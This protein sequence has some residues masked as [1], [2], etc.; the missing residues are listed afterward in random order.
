MHVEFGSADLALLEDWLQGCLLNSLNQT[1]GSQTTQLQELVMGTA[2][3]GI[4]DLFAQG[5]VEVSHDT[6][7]PNPW[8]ISW[9]GSDSRGTVRLSAD[10]NFAVADKSSYSPTR[11]SYGQVLRDRVLAAQGNAYMPAGT[12]KDVPADFRA[13][14]I[15]DMAY[16]GGIDLTMQQLGLEVEP[17]PINA[18]LTRLGI[19]RTAPH[20]SIGFAEV[21]SLIFD[22]SVLVSDN[23][24]RQPRREWTSAELGAEPDLA[25][26]EGLALA[27]F[28]YKNGGY[29]HREQFMAV[30]KQFADLI[31][32]HAS[33]D[34]SA[35][36]QAN[37]A[38]HE[39]GVILT[40][41]LGTASVDISLHLSGAGVSEAAL[42]SVLLA[43]NDEVL[44]LDEPATNLSA[45]AQRRVVTALRARTTR[46]LQTLLITHSSP[47]VPIELSDVVRLVPDVLGTIV[48]RLG[49]QPIV[50]KHADLLRHTPVRDALFA[51]GVLLT[52]GETELGA[53]Q[54]WL[55]QTE[56]T[57]EEAGVLLLDVG[58][59][60]SL[61]PHM[62]VL[63]AIGVP[64]AVLADGPAFELR[65]HHY[66]K[67]KEEFQDFQAAAAHWRQYGVFT[68]ASTFGTGVNKGKGEF[69]VFLESINREAWSEA[70]QAGAGSKPRTGASF[71]RQV[72]IPG[73][74]LDI[75]NSVRMRFEAGSR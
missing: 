32:T 12:E 64:W 67:P 45:T 10:T 11:P 43:R 4:G 62:K 59:D 41:T 22:R 75:W 2:D 42:L 37:D 24:R 71:A 30:Q 51:S 19:D 50:Q 38:S 9:I 54:I 40:P 65:L 20:R 44:V 17:K 1:L 33:L 7:R 58:G 53:L 28:Q 35:H 5:S 52:E 39:P 46:G 18:T 74:I 63:D 47:L 61:V 69:E 36:P 55:S 70:K 26:G 66:Q 6:R 23:E 49:D 48:T 3:V 16:A 13:P 73:D 34:V 27:L 60:A 72:S 57:L 68:V 14:S 21:A 31:S 8:K 29:W 56:P 25:S 15:A